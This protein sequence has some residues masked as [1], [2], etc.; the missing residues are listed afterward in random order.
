MRVRLR[1][2]RASG[3]TGIRS[4]RKVFTWAEGIIESRL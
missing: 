3:I 2:E 4:Q 1:S